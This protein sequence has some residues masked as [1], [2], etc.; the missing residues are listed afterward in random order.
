LLV[1]I[2]EATSYICKQ[3]IRCDKLDSIEP[4]HNIESPSPRCIYTIEVHE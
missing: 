2:E 4:M 1:S 3:L